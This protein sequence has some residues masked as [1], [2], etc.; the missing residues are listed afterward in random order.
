M[1]CKKSCLSTGDGQVYHELK[2]IVRPPVRMSCCLMLVAK[3]HRQLQHGQK[4]G[5]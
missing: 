4:E 3:L 1:L 2:A 5:S